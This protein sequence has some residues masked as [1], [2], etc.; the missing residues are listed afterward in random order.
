LSKIRISA[1]DFKD[2]KE[3]PDAETFENKKR[4]F[5]RKKSEVTELIFLDTQL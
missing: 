1:P 2:Y 5:G 4:Q 3:F